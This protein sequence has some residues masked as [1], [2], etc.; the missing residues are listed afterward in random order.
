MTRI[1]FYQLNPAGPDAG[2]IACALCQKA[3]D[4]GQKV[5]LL[6]A[7]ERQTEEL[8]SLLWTWRDDSFL[9]HDREEQEG[10]IT[11]ILVTHQA[12]PRGERQCL[13]NLSPE[14]PVWFAQFDR[15][16]ELV[17]EDNKSLARQHYAFYKERGYE[18]NH[19]KL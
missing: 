10:L 5:L 2:R 18:L 15:V 12:D 8:D 4:S 17:H 16:L 11:P 6:T 19:I 14:I 13:I 7:D 1:D 3:W 9:A